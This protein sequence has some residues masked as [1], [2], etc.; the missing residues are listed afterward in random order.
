MAFR[1]A[2]EP[3]RPALIASAATFSFGGAQTWRFPEGDRR[4]QQEAWYQ[5]DIC[6]ELR[7][8]TGWKGNACA[9]AFLYAAEVDPFTG[10]PTG[11][12]DNKVA[13][14][15][16]DKV[17]GGPVR[18]PQHIRTIAV[19]LEVAGEVWVIVRAGVVA[20]NGAPAD[21]E[22][23]VVSATELKRQSGRTEFVHPDTG[24]KLA[25]AGDDMIIRIWMPHPRLQLNADSAVRALLPTL[26]EI[27]KSSQNIAAR[28]DSRLAGAGIFVVPAEAD[29]PEGDDDPADPSTPNG[30]M[31]T[32][33]KTMR[34][35]LEDPGSAAAQVPIIIEVPGDVADA[36]Q[37]ITFETPLSKEVVDLRRDAIER[38]GAGLDLPREV[39]E[40]MGKSNHWSAWQVADETYKTHVLP[41][42]DLISDALTSAYYVKALT[43]ARVPNPDSY[44]LAFDGT[45]LIGQPDELDRTLQLLDRGLITDEGAQRVLGV[46]D[47]YIPQGE[48]KIRALA[49]RLLLASPA[50][51]SDPEVARA[52]GFDG[53][54]STPPVSQGG[55]A[56]PPPELPPAEGPPSR[57]A[58]GEDFRAASLAVVYALE[59]AGNRIA[60][61]QR[62][63]VEFA[64][65]A[66]HELHCRIKPEPERHTDLLDG[67]WRHTGVLAT[68]FALDQY[69]RALLATGA[70]HTDDNLREWID[71]HVA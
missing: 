42:L 6:G 64:G 53:A 18:R 38:L 28:L 39:I 43:A 19:N 32:V 63:R 47:E 56:A 1:K 55:P 69:A 26:R 62:L 70:P 17:L 13:Q 45:S 31:G 61:T 71:R 10:K 23:L 50:L 5:Y 51:L 49:L 40:G 36:F 33:A 60:N 57:T 12:T 9:Q 46:P 7:Y 15:I 4:W 2:A 66:R 58:S 22:W 59:R 48:E 54:A 14:A 68:R 21:D 29:Y 24:E 52:V 34:A 3:K 25:L 30:L 16:A 8:A 44:I 37:H 11:P 41:L 65:V 27:E 20:Q 67:A 35:S